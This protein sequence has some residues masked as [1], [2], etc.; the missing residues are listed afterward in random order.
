M[1]RG[2]LAVYL[3]RE[4]LL[5]QSKCI[6]KNSVVGF[7]HGDV[8][9]IKL[10]PRVFDLSLSTL[11]SNLPSK[12]IRMASTKN[13]AETL[14]PDG[15]YVLS[16]HHQDLVRMIK[17]I[18][19]EGRYENGIF[20]KYFTGTSLKGELRLYFEEIAINPICIILPYI[21]RKKEWRQWVSRITENIPVL[22]KFGTIVLAICKK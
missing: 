9:N 12:E 8:S 19:L 18:P 17:R 20:C 16:A 21:S 7:V 1:A 3:L 14:K 6:E 22:N 13:V 5:V 15:K 4:S 10:T 11:Y 2:A